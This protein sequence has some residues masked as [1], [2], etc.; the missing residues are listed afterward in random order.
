MRDLFSGYIVQML[1]SVGVIAAFGL[2]I[3]LLRRSFCALTGYA[4]YKILLISGAVGTPVHE[5]SHALMCI[6]FGHKITEI[7]LY[8]PNSND[9]TL[10]HVCHTYQRRNLYHQIG[11]F[12]IGAAPVILGG[13]FILL[14]LYIL[15]P[16]TFST[17][18]ADIIFINSSSTSLPISDYFAFIWKTVGALFSPDN[19]ASL[20]GWLFII[21]ALMIASH[22]EMSPADIKGGLGGLGLIAL[23]MLLI[24][25]VLCFIF[26]KAF[27]TVTDAFKSFA[28]ILS[29]FLSLSIIFLLSMLLVALIVRIIRMIIAR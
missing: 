6:I 1:C 29:A 11:N 15:L 25:L 18:S 22:T 13:G 8:D 16:E 23:L 20:N 26:P 24:D 28:L 12:F 3:H 14:L 17:V 4:G 9:G 10:G 19:L 2:I 27:F 5:L 7:K 21:L